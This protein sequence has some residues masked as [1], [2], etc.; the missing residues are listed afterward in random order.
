MDT[1]TKILDVTNIR[2]S[3]IDK[4][5]RIK[6]KSN[7]T[8]T[9]RLNI[10]YE[11][12]TL[13]VPQ[14]KR[15]S[16][17][18]YEMLCDYVDE[19]LLK[20]GT[21]LVR[22]SKRIEISASYYNDIYYLLFNIAEA[23]VTHSYIKNFSYFSPSYSLII[24][25]GHLGLANKNLIIDKI[26]ELENIVE[27]A[28]VETLR[29]FNLT[30]NGL[31]RRWWDFD[32]K[33]RSEVKMGTKALNVLR[34]TPARDTVIWNVHSAREQIVHL[35]I[36]LW[37]SIFTGLSKDIEWDLSVKYYL[38]KIIQS[39]AIAYTTNDSSKI[40]GSLMKIS[41]NI[42]RESIPNFRPLATS[43]ESQILR[44]TLP[45]EVIDSMELKIKKFKDNLKVSTIDTILKDLIIENPADWKSIVSRVNLE[46][47]DDRYNVLLE[48]QENENIIRILK[49][50]IDTTRDKDM[51][52]VSLY[53]L[54]TTDKL[55]PKYRKVLE[56]LIY[57]SNM[58]IYKRHVTNKDA[59][60]LELINEIISLQNP[61][62]RTVKID[63]SKLELTRTALKQTVSVINEFI[64]EE[65]ESVEEIKTEDDTPEEILEDKFI[66]YD[67]I[68]RLLN[69]GN[70]AMSEANDIAK[71]NGMLLNTYINEINKVL[72]EY[73][74]DQVIVI[75]ND[76]IS[77]D[78][79]YIENMKELVNED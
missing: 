61:M 69:T 30:D 16:L 67:F 75:E 77:I 34:A 32:G 27:P 15:E 33:L 53:L 36:D 39:E 70:L 22:M 28:E 49:L 46:G 5:N 62:R 78:S 9:D 1:K 11:R 50:I 31:P 57:T 19:I 76:T 4:T 72:Y 66:G 43:K 29:F 7:K 64:G 65:I 2:A 21:T 60:D 48:Y 38:R 68:L 24:L 59:L 20:E 51:Q 47:A 56:S 35:Y 23:H 44:N 18:L 8:W 6:P 17:R 3:K 58:S 73:V 10:P 26:T 40:L 79:F 14:I 41:E 54:E 55:T 45:K 71:E 12:Q 25:E 63:K 37:N 13:K 42:L 74:D 52:L